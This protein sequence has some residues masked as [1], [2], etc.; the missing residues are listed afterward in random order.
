MRYAAYFV[1]ALVV[2]LTSFVAWR[3]RSVRRG[4]ARRDGRIRE[5]LE[6]LGRRLQQPAPPD[7]AEILALAARPEA[8]GMLHAL[9]TRFGK[10]AAFPEEY[11]TRE[12]HAESMLV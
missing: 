12:R 2:L 4:A 6:P 9:L 10:V 1:L 8:R 3:V 11:R 5:L 7:P